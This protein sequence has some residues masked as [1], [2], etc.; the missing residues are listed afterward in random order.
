MWCDVIENRQA[1]EKSV[2]RTR[3]HVENYFKEAPIE[4]FLLV[5]TRNSISTHYILNKSMLD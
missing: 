3:K 2:F 4:T 5:G 1:V